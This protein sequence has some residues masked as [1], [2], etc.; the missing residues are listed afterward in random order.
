[1]E[2]KAEEV[3]QLQDV[4]DQGQGKGP[5]LEVVLDTGKAS[6]HLSH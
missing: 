2:R 4:V 6:S 1:M 3:G 5:D